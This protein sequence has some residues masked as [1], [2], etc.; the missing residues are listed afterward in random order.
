MRN[1]NLERNSAIQTQP[2]MRRKHTGKP[3]F[4]NDTRRLGRLVRLTFTTLVGVAVAFGAFYYWD[5]YVHIGDQT[6][7]E[8]GIAELER[9]S[10]AHP[11][12]PTVRLALAENYLRDARYREAV[13][14]AEQVLDVYPQEERAILIIGLGHTLSGE[15]RKGLPFLEQYV[16]L[17]SE[18]P[19]AGA[20]MSLETA[21]YYL[22]ENY[23]QLDRPQDAVAILEQAL[24]ISP[25]DADAQYLLG[26]A[27][28]RTGEYGDAIENFQV[29][30]SFVPDF[31]EAY[32]GM[33]EAY[34]VLGFDAHASYARGMV[35]FSEMDYSRAVQLLQE[36]AVDLPDYAPVHLG[37][38][39][40]LEQIGD[41]ASARDSLER[42]VQIEPQNFAAT[43]A[44]KRVELS[45]AQ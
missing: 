14:T 30:I 28:L 29:A 7:A 9:Q 40:S 27:N 12:D 32:A 44:L 24:V 45:L 25:S 42:A 11:N 16:S 33:A 31:R 10:L 37:L 17:R 22:G 41:F 18:L 8:I 3:A 35:A 5:R 6:P 21:L 13:Q 26:I 43:I 39:L 4:W 36:A 15:R 19:A 23:I 20:D 34:E 1:L 38:G 2:V